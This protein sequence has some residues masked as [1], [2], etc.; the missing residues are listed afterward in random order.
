MTRH[1]FLVFLIA[2]MKEKEFKDENLHIYKY[3]FKSTYLQAKIYK[4]IFTSTYLQV[5]IYRQKF[6]I[7]YLQTVV[8]A[9]KS[10]LFITV[11]CIRQNIKILQKKTIC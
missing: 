5:H 2:A 7:T 11:G 1:Y 10:T 3:K 4:Y 8:D 9:A 6:T